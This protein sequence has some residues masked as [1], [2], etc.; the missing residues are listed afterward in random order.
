M[1]KDEEQCQY[2]DSLSQFLLNYSK[3]NNIKLIPTATLY[4]L[5]V[6]K[7]SNIPSVEQAS[8]LFQ[9]IDDIKQLDSRIFG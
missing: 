2:I 7:Q 8:F 1:Q 5:W 4:N 3:K 6:E 9:Y